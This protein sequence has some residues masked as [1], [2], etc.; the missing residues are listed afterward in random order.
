MA[1]F[2]GDAGKLQKYIPADEGRSRV[3]SSDL[4]SAVK[5]VLP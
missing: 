2:D 3:V 1:F 4:R 5:K